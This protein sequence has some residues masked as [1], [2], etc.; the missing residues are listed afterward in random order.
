MSKNPCL[1]SVR[2]LVT[3]SEFYTAEILNEYVIIGNDA[4]LKCN[5]PSFVA[6]FVSVVGWVDSQGQGY[7]RMGGKYGSGDMHMNGRIALRV[8]GS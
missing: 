2:P 7:D 4:L 6:D 8:L 3:S 1:V 5:I